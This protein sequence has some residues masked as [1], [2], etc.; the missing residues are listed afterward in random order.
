[1][2]GREGRSPEGGMKGATYN[3]K[4]CNADSA[5]R[6]GAAKVNN[7]NIGGRVGSGKGTSAVGPSGMMLPAGHRRK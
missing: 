7:P 6:M 3:R 2:A 5:A 4:A 1:M